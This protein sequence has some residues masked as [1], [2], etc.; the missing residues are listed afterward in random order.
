MHCWLRLCWLAGYASDARLLDATA[1]VTTARGALSGGRICNCLGCPG[2][3]QGHA[4]QMQAKL[5]GVGHSDTAYC[6]P[7]SIAKPRSRHNN[8]YG[9]NKAR[10]ASGMS[11]SFFTHLRL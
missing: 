3:I 1:G 6:S 11:M 10:E 8:V 5:V 7:Y 2:L 4:G 9:L